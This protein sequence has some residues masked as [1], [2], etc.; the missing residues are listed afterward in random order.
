MSIF[1]DIK[2]F[3]SKGLLSLAAAC[4]GLVV[5][6]F[7][8]L[9]V[10]DRQVFLEADVVKLVI[11]SASI[12]SPSFVALFATTLI[13]ERVFTQ[14]HPQTAGRFGGFKEW[15]VTHSFSNSTIFFTAFL[16]YFVAQLSFRGFVGWIIGL[17]LVYVGFEFYR[18]VLLAKGQ[19]K[20]HFED[21]SDES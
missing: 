14:L 9:Y 19:A 4:L 7:L 8:T 20:P 5:P 3:D 10:F 21:P 12:A 11:L 16:I 2:A 1:S 13:G 17:L 15:L 6:G 18:L